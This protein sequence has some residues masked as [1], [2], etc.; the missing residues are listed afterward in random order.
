MFIIRLG[1]AEAADVKSGPWNLDAVPRLR[2]GGTESR[3]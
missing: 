2:R 1:I 3:G